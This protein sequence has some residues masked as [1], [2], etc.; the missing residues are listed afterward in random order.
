MPPNATTVLNNSPRVDH[1]H[2]ACNLP[3]HLHGNVH[4]TPLVTIRTGD[5]N[6]DG[7]GVTNLRSATRDQLTPCKRHHHNFC[8][9]WNIRGAYIVL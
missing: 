5:D 1:G 2:P 8:Q 9:I 6:G 4:T 3:T 7:S